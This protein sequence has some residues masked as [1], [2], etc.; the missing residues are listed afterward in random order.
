MSTQSSELQ[1]PA[2]TAAPYRV[3]VSLTGTAAQDGRIQTEYVDL[4]P[5]EVEDL[6][7]LLRLLGHKP[8]QTLAI[9]R[10]KFPTGHSGEGE[11]R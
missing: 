5:S 3:S 9:T 7:V 4:S 11:D 6:R 2:A 10:V 1:P 8:A